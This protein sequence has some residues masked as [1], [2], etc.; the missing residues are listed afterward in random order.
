MA[1]R[2]SFSSQAAVCKNHHGQIIEM[3][4]RSQPNYTP[5]KGEALVARLATSLASSLHLKKFI[6]EGDSQAVILALQQPT[7]IQDWH[8][9]DIIQDSLDSIPSDS[10]WSAW[11]VNRSANFSAHYVTYW[12]TTKFAFSS[13]PTSYTPISSIPVVS[14]NDPPRL[15]DLAL[16]SDRDFH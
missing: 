14:G 4:S 6:P 1:I 2:D 13:I 5:N 8:I 10:S 16:A 9:I 12:A 3:T 15:V 11:K 7:I